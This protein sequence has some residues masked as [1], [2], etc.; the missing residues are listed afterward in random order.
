MSKTFVTSNLQLGRPAAIKKY[1][2]SHDDV[3][4]MTD[5]LI[6]KWNETVKQE[7]VVYHLGNFAHD[8][9]TAQAVLSRLN[10]TIKFIQGDHDNAITLLNEKGMLPSRCSMLKCVEIIEDLN[11]AVSYW[12]LGAWPN[13]TNK[14]WSIIGYPD[15]K[16]KSDPKKR[17][18]NVSTDL[19]ANKPQE[20]EKLLGI[21]SD[22]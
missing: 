13:K 5:D 8:P 6:L 22:F 7:D 14:S 3:D 1:K 16:Y 17:I 10:G 9:K 18:I 4:H 21:F 15:K 11:V 20:L 2:R 12:P 19:W